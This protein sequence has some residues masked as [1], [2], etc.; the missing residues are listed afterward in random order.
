MA[1]PYRPIANF[2]G[3]GCSYRGDKDQI[4]IDEEFN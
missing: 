3:G 4:R 1:I 2:V